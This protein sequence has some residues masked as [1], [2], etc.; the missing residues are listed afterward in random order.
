ML[1]T[2][3]NSGDKVGYRKDKSIHLYGI[4]QTYELDKT[5]ISLC[6]VFLG[7]ESESWLGR[8]WVGVE[9]GEGGH[10]FK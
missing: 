8:A 10:N 4:K 6:Y 9:E 2:I 5:C 1:G 3:K 7:E